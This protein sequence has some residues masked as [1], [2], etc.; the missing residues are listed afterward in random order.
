MKPGGLLLLLL[1]T[2]LL[3][4]ELLAAP[5]QKASGISSQRT[6]LLRALLKDPEVAPK[7]R[8]LEGHPESREGKSECKGTIPPKQSPGFKRGILPSEETTPD[9]T[10]KPVCKKKPRPVSKMETG[11]PGK[12]EPVEKA[13]VGSEGTLFGKKPDLGVG[14]VSGEK[15]AP[16]GKPPSGEIPASPD[17][18]NSAAKPALSEKLWSTMADVT[19][20]EATPGDKPK[21]GGTPISPIQPGKPTA[22]GE[23][24]SS[25]KP[26]AAQAHTS[27][28]KPVSCGKP[29]SD[30]KPV[31]PLGSMPFGSKPMP[32]GKPASEAGEGTHAKPA[33]QGKPGSSEKPKPE[34][35]PEKEAED[36]E[37]EASFEEDAEDEVEEEV[38][39][40]NPDPS[41][42]SRD[43]GEDA[44]DKE[45][46]YGLDPS[47]YN[48]YAYHD[49]WNDDEDDLDNTSF[50]ATEGGATESSNGDREPVFDAWGDEVLAR[51]LRPEPQPRRL[52]AERGSLWDVTED[53]DAQEAGL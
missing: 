18:A 31:S 21:P 47:P 17:S 10:E 27:H 42:G 22:G 32:G 13:H 28:G 15:L 46:D 12:V 14:M 43:E 11:S 2:F 53:V 51:G 23:P 3:W 5:A 30:G 26:N 34:E 44:L 7:N 40:D 29:V 20:E 41:E 1:G 8:V 25:G 36:A 48:A 35:K 33:P 6:T 39:A 45:L 24:E 50:V 52:P 38:E 9:V 37:Q 16:S 19:S 49:A 4:T